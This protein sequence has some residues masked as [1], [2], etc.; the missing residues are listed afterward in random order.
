M[1]RVT[2]IKK[3][4]WKGRHTEERY[5]ALID[6][7]DRAIQKKLDEMNKPY[8]ENF[9]GVIG[10]YNLMTTTGLYGYAEYCLQCARDRYCKDR[11]SSAVGLTMIGALFHYGE[12]T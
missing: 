2:I 9:W 7:T 10:D 12:E 4:F 11:H 5:E 6:M 8:R 3:T 1:K